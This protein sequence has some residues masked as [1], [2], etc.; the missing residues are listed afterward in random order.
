MFE[1][2]P[3]LTVETIEVNGVIVHRVD[4]FYLDPESLVKQCLYPLP[5]PW[6]DH[7]VKNEI[8]A[9]DRRHQIYAPDDMHAVQNRIREIL[10]DLNGGVLLPDLFRTN[11]T[12]LRREVDFESNYWWPHQDKIYWNVLIYLTEGEDQGTNFYEVKNREHFDNKYSQE[13]TTPWIPKTEF[14]LI[15]YEPSVFNRLVCFD[16]AVYHGARFSE[17]SYSSFRLNQVLFFY[18]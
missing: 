3:N 4:N 14:E 9:N 16:G 18:K 17:Q 5:P 12:H 15:H 11:M 10:P 7:S 6:K 1:I 2:S 8:W 13:E